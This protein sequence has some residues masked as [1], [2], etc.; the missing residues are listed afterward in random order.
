MRN[1]GFSFQYHLCDPCLAEISI[2]HFNVQSC[3][4]LIFKYQPVRLHYA[5]LLYWAINSNQN[6]T[7]SCEKYHLG[8]P[9]HKNII[10]ISNCSFNNGLPIIHMHVN[11]STAGFW[12]TRA[13]HSALF[14]SRC[15][16]Q[17]PPQPV[18]DIC[19]RARFSSNCNN[20]SDCSGR[21]ICC[22][23]ECNVKNCQ[24]PPRRQY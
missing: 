22:I 4:L 20:D 6:L 8:F 5:L 11:V 24:D 17:S 18:P 3:L 19:T 12:T 14:C 9:N 23:N 13:S 16:I 10:L 1:E 7:K 21:Q 15:P 2:G